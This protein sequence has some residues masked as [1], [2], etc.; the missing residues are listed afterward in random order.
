MA[1][2]TM[3]VSGKHEENK[4]GHQVLGGFEDNK[5]FICDNKDCHYLLAKNNKHYKYTNILSR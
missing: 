3:E 4:L 2:K 5:C 1:V